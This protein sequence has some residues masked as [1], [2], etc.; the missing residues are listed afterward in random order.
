MPRYR[1]RITYDMGMS[2]G[3][4]TYEFTAKNDKAAQNFC[5]RHEGE[6]VG[7]IKRGVHFDTSTLSRVVGS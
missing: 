5:K 7:P 6:D 3:E 1:V 4:E 2:K